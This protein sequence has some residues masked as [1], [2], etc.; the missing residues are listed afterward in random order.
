MNIAEAYTHHSRWQASQAHRL[1][2]LVS[3]NPGARVVD[4]GCGTGEIARIIASLVGPR[5]T[6]EGIDTDA[7]RLQQARLHSS[8]PA[9]RF[10]LGTAECLCGFAS[11]GY[12]LVFSNFVFHWIKNKRASL[13]EAKRVLRIGGVLAF[14][15]IAGLPTQLMELTTATGSCGDGLLRKLHFSGLDELVQ[16]TESAGLKIE[17]AECV[18]EVNCFSSYEALSRF[19]E[20]TTAG[21][22]DAARLPEAVAP[23]SLNSRNIIV[24]EDV[25]RII[26][27]K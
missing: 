2:N 15:T 13:A 19:W 8:N 12:D 7:L 23:T 6:V 1:L 5:G 18:K 24:I 21:L 4:I 9:I 20:A 26:A 16:L 17:R 10:H 3:V 14:S 22:F 25:I 27:R 11:S